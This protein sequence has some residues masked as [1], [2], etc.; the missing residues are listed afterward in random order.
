MAF[1]FA[2]RCREN[3]S[4][5]PQ[6]SK[7]IPRLEYRGHESIACRVQNSDLD[8]F[9]ADLDVRESRESILISVALELIGLGHPPMLLSIIPLRLA[10]AIRSELCVEHGDRS[11]RRR[12][13]VLGLLARSP[14]VGPWVGRTTRNVDSSR[15]VAVNAVVFSIQINTDRT[16]QANDLDLLDEGLLRVRATS[17]HS[18]RERITVR[19]ISVGRENFLSTPRRFD[20]GADS[21]REFVPAPQLPAGSIVWKQFLTCECEASNA[22]D[23]SHGQ[24]S[25]TF[26]ARNSPLLS[27]AFP[28]SPSVVL[29]HPKFTV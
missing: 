25:R 11:F 20:G 18:V 22:H 5:L 24:H 26:C 7:K 28:T 13:F 4:P 8:L 23:R 14:P 1:A 27:N 12:T 19:Q 2:A 29:V 6:V 15:K 16:T 17:D 10:F 3:S 9:L 21:G